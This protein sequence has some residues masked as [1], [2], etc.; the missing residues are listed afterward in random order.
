MGNVLDKSCRENENTH[1]MYNNFF[2]EN[3]T[4]FYICRNICD[5]D[6]GATN[7]VTTWHIRVACWISKVTC[8]YDHAHAHAPRYPHART[9]AHE[10]THRTMK[11]TYRFCTVTMITNVTQSYVIVHFLYCCMLPTPRNF[12]SV[13]RIPGLSVPLLPP[14]V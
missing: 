1:V 14:I 11:S 2:S 13:V 7:D 5:G 9:H 4:I 6:R 10:C 3:Y 12:L 8:T